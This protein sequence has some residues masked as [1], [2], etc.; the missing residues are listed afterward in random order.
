MRRRDFMTLLG[1]VATLPFAAEAQ[2]GA[3]IDAW[4]RKAV[5]GNMTTGV[6]AI[7]T[8][9]ERVLY[10]GAFGLADTGRAMTADALFRIASMTKA[11]TS[12]AAMQLIESGKV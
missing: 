7:A 11:V 2:T 12:T 4:L 10:R 8:D 1:G 3:G 5:D 9:R 6:V